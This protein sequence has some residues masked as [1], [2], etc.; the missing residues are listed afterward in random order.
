MRLLIVQYA[1]DYREAFEGFAEGKGETY[2]AQKYSVDAVAEMGK[3]CEE[4]TVICC[5]TAEPYD[6]VLANGVR[7]IG[8]GFTDKINTGSLVQLIAKQRPTHL[9]MRTPMRAVFRWAVKHKVKTIATLADSF[10]TEGFRNKIRNYLLSRQLNKNHIEWIGNHGINSC[11]SLQATGV[12]S[13][14]IIP[15]DWPAR[16]T[17]DLFEPKTLP[18]D[19]ITW[20]LVFVGSITESKGLGDV[21]AAVAK[22]KAQNLSVN[23]KIAGQGEVEKFTDRA[24]ELEIAESVEFLGMLENNRVVHLM[25]DADLV[26]VPSHHEYPEGLPMTI[27]EA[28]CSRTPI[29]ASDHPMFQNNLIHGESAMIFSASDSVDLAEQIEKLVSDPALYQSISLAAADAWKRLQLPVQWAM[30]IE[31]WLDGSEE[32]RQWLQKHAISSEIYNSRLA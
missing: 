5:L 29:I 18:V 4:V 32:N 3:R 25:R 19:K 21:L 15:W 16:F 27:Y 23:L 2:Y 6:V 10:S 31:R 30:M 13:D 28:L 26:V 9:V 11:L 14:K 12:K 22:L 7:A 17:P 24:K 20:N 8:A 1:G